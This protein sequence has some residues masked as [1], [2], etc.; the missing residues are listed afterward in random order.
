MHAPKWQANVAALLLYEA[1]TP[2]KWPIGSIGRQ[3][4]V[5]SITQQWPTAAEDMYP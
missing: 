4:S 5:D 3:A 1:D 2:A